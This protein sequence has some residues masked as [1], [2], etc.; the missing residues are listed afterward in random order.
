MALS[1]F[2]APA[3]VHTTRK[4]HLSSPRRRP[5]ATA[6]AVK[7]W[8]EYEK[9]VK[10]KDLARALR[11]LQSTD[12]LLPLKKEELST[13]PTSA[14]AELRFFREERD[15][16][17]LDTCLNADDMKLVGSAYRFLQQRGFLPNF[18]KCRNIGM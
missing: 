7:E 3:L 10:E 12:G 9:A 8:R 2:F 14:E 4:L 16:E 18:G 5:T 13:I 15:W 6:K 11:F 17:V 1:F